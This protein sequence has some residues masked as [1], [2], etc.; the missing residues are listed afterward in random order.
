MGKG[1]AATTAVIARLDGRPSIPETLVLNRDGAAYWV[2]RLGGRR[3]SG[4]KAAQRR[5]RLLLHI[6]DAGKDDALGALTGVAEIELVLGQKHRI[7][8]DVVGDAGAVGG[9]ESIELLAIVG[10]NPA[11]ELEFAHFKLHRQRIFRVEPRLQHVEL[12]RAD[13]AD[14]RPR[15]IAGAEH[16]AQ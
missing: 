4:P 7:A 14:Q 16:R 8:V 15:A 5:S 9:D 11:R 2:P 1:A 12:Q 13:H 6:L 3:R 10:G